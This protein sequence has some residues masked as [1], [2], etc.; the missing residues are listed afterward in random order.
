MLEGAP[1]P[2][3]VLAGPLPLVELAGLG[4]ALP[5]VL[6]LSPVIVV[7]V[8]LT[9]T[10][11]LELDASVDDETVEGRGLGLVVCSDPASVAVTNTPPCTLPGW[12]DLITFFAASAN[13]VMLWPDEG[14]LMTPTIPLWQCW[15]TEQ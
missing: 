7:A 6:V 11:E 10:L 14:G 15:A 3:V 8:A 5:L 1:D 4:A 9:L 13:C 12:E 2:V